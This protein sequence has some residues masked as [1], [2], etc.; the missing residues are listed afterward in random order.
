MQQLPTRKPSDTHK[1]IEHVFFREPSSQNPPP[2]AD[3][4]S[5]LQQTTAVQQHSQP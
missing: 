1:L 5:I 4:N 3:N 2:Y